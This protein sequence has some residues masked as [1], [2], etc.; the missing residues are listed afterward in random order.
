MVASVT[1]G[2]GRE[3]M[4]TQPDPGEENAVLVVRRRKARDAVLFV[5]SAALLFAVIA[6]VSWQVSRPKPR[7]VAAASAPP[8]A[9]PVEPPVAASVHSASNYVQ[10]APPP[11]T[12]AARPSMPGTRPKR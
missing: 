10:T 1:C 4:Q 3:A 6:L 12:S 9:A 2:A 8:A 7:P 5:S 11:A